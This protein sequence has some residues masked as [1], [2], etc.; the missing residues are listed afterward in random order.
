M[1]FGL[2]KLPESDKKCVYLFWHNPRTCLTHTHRHTYT[3]QRYIVGKV[4][5]GENLCVLVGVVGKNFVSPQCKFYFLTVQCFDVRHSLGYSERRILKTIRRTAYRYTDQS[6]TC[7]RI[8]HERTIY[9]PCR[10]RPYLWLCP[11]NFP[12]NCLMQRCLWFIKFIWIWFWPT[13]AVIA[14]SMFWSYS[15][16][17][18]SMLNF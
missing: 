2:E 12:K 4:H 14:M 16:H 5:C 17:I 9:R 6:H 13:G 10:H 15:I 8:T 18:Y 11:K 3:Y 1:P 7:S